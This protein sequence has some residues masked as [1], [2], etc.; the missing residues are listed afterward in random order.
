MDGTRDYPSIRQTA[1]DDKSAEAGEYFRQLRTWANLDTQLHDVA[2]GLDYLHDLPF[3]H[4]DIKSVSVGSLILHHGLMAPQANILIN[5]DLSA[6]IGDFGLTNITSTASISMVLSAPLSGGTCRWMA[7]ELIK[8]DDAGGAPRKPSKESDV[9]A[10]AM[11]AY[12]VNTVIRH[13]SGWLGAE[14]SPDFCALCAFQA[15][16]FRLPGHPR[17]HRWESAGATAASRSTRT[18]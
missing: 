11:M 1:Q 9:Y 2:S 3:V 18:R 13:L 17:R 10:F 4:S 16:Q 6:C 12:E 14:K 15:P 7:P 8:S 5:N